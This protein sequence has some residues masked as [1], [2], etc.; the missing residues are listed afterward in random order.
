MRH[1]RVYGASCCRGAYTSRRGAVPTGKAGNFAGACPGFREGG[2]AC[3]SLRGEEHRHRAYAF[4]HA[5]TNGLRRCSGARH[6]RSQPCTSLQKYD[7]CHGTSGG[8]CPYAKQPGRQRGG[9]SS[10][11]FGEVYDRFDC[12]RASR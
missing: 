6:S 8:V 9:K 11:S 3:R 12:P 4:G 1:R 5:G 7:V 2:A 10:A